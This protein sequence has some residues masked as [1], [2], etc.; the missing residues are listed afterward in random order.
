MSTTTRPRVEVGG[1]AAMLYLDVAS[2]IGDM[3]AYV[4]ETF[5][6]LTEKQHSALVESAILHASNLEGRF[7]ARIVKELER[8]D[9]DV[10]GLPADISKIM[11]REDGDA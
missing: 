3:L 11:G 5:S 2:A 6:P 9:I 4:Q 8:E 1:L 7:V 10:Y